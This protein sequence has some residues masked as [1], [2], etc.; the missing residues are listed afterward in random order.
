MHDAGA[1]TIAEAE[2]SCIV[3]GMPTDAIKLG[4]A[5]EV[6]ALPHVAGGVIGALGVGA[7]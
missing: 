5:C 7:R 3:F 4:A 1:H 6:L 2:S